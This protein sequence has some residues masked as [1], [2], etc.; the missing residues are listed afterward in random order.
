LAGDTITA[1]P[2]TWSGTGPLSYS[3]QWLRCTSPTDPL[4]CEAIAGATALTYTASAADVTAGYLRLRVAAANEIEPAGVSALSPASQ[5]VTVPAAPVAPV[6]PATAE[7]AAPVGLTPAAIAAGLEVTAA[8]TVQIPLSCPA[9]PSGCDADGTLSIALGANTASV[10]ARSAASVKAQSATAGETVLAQFAGV[11]IAGGQTKLVSVRLTP[12]V[13]GRLQVRGV[14]KV[15]VTL[16]TNSHLNGQIPVSSVQHVWL[17]I[18]AL[19]CTTSHTL[20]VHWV[21]RHGVRLRSIVISS[22]GHT[23]ARPAVGNLTATIKLGAK[24]PSL[25]RITIAAVTTTGH[26]LASQR[27]RLLCGGRLPAGYHKV[28]TLVLQPAG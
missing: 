8:G 5:R 9:T 16:S 18:P 14:R 22:N 1:E 13:L 4:T 19:L 24:S 3:Y 25:T 26:K 12:A 2:G 20:A 15:R 27:M 23:V 10:K 7:N 21:L 6:A 11:Q 17:Y 28:K